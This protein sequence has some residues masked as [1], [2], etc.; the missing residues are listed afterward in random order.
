MALSLWHWSQ[1]DELSE[2]WKGPTVILVGILI[3]G[4]YYSINFEEKG[5][6]SLEIPA[7]PT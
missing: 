4:F 5:L 2:Q 1:R 6:H 7:S 3:E